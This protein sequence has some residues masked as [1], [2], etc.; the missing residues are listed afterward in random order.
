MVVTYKR[1]TQ[2]VYFLDSCVHT[3]I[4][5]Q[6][7]SSEGASRHGGLQVALYADLPTHYMSEECRF[8]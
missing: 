7:P 8:D 2:Q 5:S 4:V 6:R 1:N 3:V